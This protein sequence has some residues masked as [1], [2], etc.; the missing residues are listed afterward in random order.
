MVDYLNNTQ[1]SLTV[2]C[3][4]VGDALHS[5]TVQHSVVAFDA[6][7]PAGSN[8]WMEI[9]STIKALANPTDALDA[10]QSPGQVVFASPSATTF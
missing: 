2:K 3:S 9:A 5:L 4:P 6:A 7:S 1:P 10:K 8:K